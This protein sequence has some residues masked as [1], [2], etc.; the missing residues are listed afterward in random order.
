MRIQQNNQQMRNSMME[1]QSVSTGI[2]DS[3][4]QNTQQNQM[5]GMGQSL[6]QAMSNQQ[7]RSSM[8]QAPPPVPQNQ[9]QGYNMN[10]SREDYRRAQDLQRAYETA[11]KDNKDINSKI[12]DLMN[13]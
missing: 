11:M 7:P 3:V 5:S 2:A 6:M 12:D 1:T 10:Q 9:S 8:Q 4:V 13:S